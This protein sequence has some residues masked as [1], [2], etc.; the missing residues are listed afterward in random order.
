MRQLKKKYDLGSLVSIFFSRNTK[1]GQRQGNSQNKRYTHTLSSGLASTDASQRCMRGPWS[2]VKR[3]NW[4]VK[5]VFCQTWNI[6][7]DWANLSVVPCAKES[8]QSSSAVQ[9]VSSAQLS[10]PFKTWK[11]EESHFE[12]LTVKHIQILNMTSKV[13]ANTLTSIILLLRH[14]KDIKEENL[15]RT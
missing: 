11:E 3:D 13:F 9:I 4:P 2:H 12:Q 8:S 1:R 6:G 5:P 10:E 15:V 14:K 7:R